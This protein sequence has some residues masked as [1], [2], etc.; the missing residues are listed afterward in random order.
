VLE[1]ADYIPWGNLGNA[2]LADAKTAHQAHAAFQQAAEH[3]Q[4]YVEIK[5]NDAT[6][7]A[8]LGW[9]RANLGQAEQARELVRRSE[10]LRGEPMEIALFNAQTLAVLGDI[11]QA[12]QRVAAAR[13]AGLPE[14]RI[15]TNV[16]L[17]RAG[18]AST[19]PASKS[20]A[21]PA[22]SD[23]GGHPPGE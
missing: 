3:A 13:A 20:T 14:T 22:P 18:I 10:T 21:S 8:A 23:A 9:F 16:V 5:S 12:R 2:L 11:D 19:P 7:L 15:A 1:P 4:H 17:R 6:A